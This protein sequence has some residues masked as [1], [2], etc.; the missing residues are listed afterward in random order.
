MLDLPAIVENPD[1]D[2][3]AELPQFC[4]I[5]GPKPAVLRVKIPTAL[6]TTSIAAGGPVWPL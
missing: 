6:A 5:A 4:T 2:V 1:V 3:D